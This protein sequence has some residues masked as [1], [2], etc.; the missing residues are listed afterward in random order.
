MTTLLDLETAK[1]VNRRLDAVGAGRAGSLAGS[2][3][4]AELERESAGEFEGAYGL[5]ATAYELGAEG[6]AVR[7]PWRF[8][9]ADPGPVLRSVHESPEAVELVSELAGVEMGPSKASYLYF[10]DGGDFIGFHTD[11]PACEVVLL[12]GISVESAELVLYPHLEHADPAELLELSRRADAAPDG[13]R[14]LPVEAGGLTALVGRRVPHQT[15]KA[16]R[17]RRV[18]QASLCYAGRG[19]AS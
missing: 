12:V 13:G 8:A 6:Q 1:E 2:D 7:S 14:A 10:R 16:P 18:V 17:S 3:L 11:V 19:R 9:V 15:P 5:E 4:V